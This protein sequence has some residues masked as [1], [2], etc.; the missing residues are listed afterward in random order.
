M[1][2]RR[3]RVFVVAGGLVLLALAF[4]L[5]HK[6]TRTVTETQ[7]VP[8]PIEADPT[9]P[10]N[11]Q[12]SLWAHNL[13]LN[14]GPHFRVYVRWIHG[15][16]M[17]TERN[18][19]PDFDVPSSF[20]LEIEKGMVD[21]KLSD[22]AEFL[23]SGQRGDPPLK[24]MKVE[25]RDG[26][27]QISGTAHKGV[28]VPVRL[29]AELTPLPDGR[30]KLH[31]KKVNVLKVPMK[32]LFGL[33]HV[34]LDDLMPKTNVPGMQVS[35]DDIYLDTQTLLPPPHIHGH[36]TS[37][38]LLN[39][40]ARV[41][42]G[43]V[44]ESEEQLAQWHNFLRLSGGTVS[45][46]K[47][48]M[49]QADLT[50]VDAANDEWFDLDLANYQTQLV[51]GTMRTTAQAGVEAYMPDLDRL[52]PGAATAAQGVSVQWLRDRNTT[53]PMQVAPPHR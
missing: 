19:A 43:G 12:T 24:N 22:T 38:Q 51:Y 47:L 32:G 34:K 25:N 29:D 16:M 6:T 1:D 50:L 36:I 48:T 18:R 21:A 31:V 35:G 44:T 8:E 4:W 49:R 28:S 26:E 13:L 45:F 5:G 39:D 37:V 10:D 15:R 20:V 41:I 42:Y 33:F 30:L 9:T 7:V 11:Q 53:P 2:L 40:R 17:R 14:Q 52:P 23:N 3:W 46:G 27:V